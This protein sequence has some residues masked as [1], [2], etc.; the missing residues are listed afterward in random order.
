LRVDEAY[1]LGSLVAGE[2][3]AADLVYVGRTE[4]VTFSNHKRDGSFAPFLIGLA[5]HGCIGDARV[6]EQHALDLSEVDILATR[7]AHIQ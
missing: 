4:V 3:S 1:R 5:N 2:A 6:V 7:L